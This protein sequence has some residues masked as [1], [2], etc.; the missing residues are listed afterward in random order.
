M[1]AFALGGMCG[2][3]VTLVVLALGSKD[4]APAPYVEDAGAEAST[5]RRVVERVTVQG[6]CDERVAELEAEVQ[7]LSLMGAIASGRVE[8]HEGVEQPWPDDVPERFTAASIEAAVTTALEQVEGGELLEVDCSEYPCIAWMQS[9]LD[10]DPEVWTSSFE[11][12]HDAVGNGEEGVD[13]S[14]HSYGENPR[15]QAVTVSWTDADV[16]EEAASV[17]TGFRRDTVAADYQAELAEEAPR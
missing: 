10:A 3:A 6:D 11:P 17:R 13:L 9:H 16:D 7:R 12:V 5:E 15:L 1:K 8:G 2:V 4:T 14:V